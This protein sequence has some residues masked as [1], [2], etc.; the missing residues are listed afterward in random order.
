MSALAP[1]LQAFFI[2]RLGHQRQASPGTVASYRDAFRLLLG[3]ARARTGKEPSQL[4]FTDLDATFVSGFLDHLEHER[5]NSARTR[6]ARLAALRSFYRFA[7]YR[8][9]EHA[10]LIA[11]VL[12]IPE[13]RSNATAMTFLDRREAE[14][15]LAAPDQTTWAGRR[16]H[17]L[18]VVALQTGFRLSELTGLARADVHLGTGAHVT[19]RGKGRKQRSTPLRRE[20]AAVVRAWLRERTGEPSDPLFPSLH[21]SAL[22]ADAVQ[23]LVAKHVRRAQTACPS[24]ARKH[25]TPHTLRHTCAMTLQR[26]GVASDATFGRSREH[27]LPAPQRAALRR[28]S[29]CR[30][31][32]RL[33]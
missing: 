32:A 9:P 28:P 6:N 30:D 23:R 7:S 33:R 3:Y 13:K 25:V 20:G 10:G 12:A 5:D 27:A 26:R 1:T 31:A 14:A 21:G 29:A 2:T 11:Q 17:A 16:D 19:C 15:L 22:S 18:L 24:L 4:D 8:H